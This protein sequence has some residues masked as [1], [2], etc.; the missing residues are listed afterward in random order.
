MKLIECSHIGARPQ[1]EFSYGGAVRDVVDPGSA[2]ESHWGRYVFNRDSVPGVKR[3]W[4]YHN[5][6]GMWFVL[7][8]DTV[9]D[10]I[11]GEVEMS[12]VRHEF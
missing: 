5:P 12:E 6:T 7:E 2:S 9:S 3:E 4:W 10:E 11:V 1:S 8:R